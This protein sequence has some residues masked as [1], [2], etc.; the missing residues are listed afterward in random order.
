[1]SV[2]EHGAEACN[3]LLAVDVEMNTVD[4]Y[5]MSSW[6]RGYGDFE[7][8]PDSRT[9]RRAVA[10][11]HGAVPRGPRVGRRRAP[12]VASPRQILRRQ[13]D[14]LAERGLEAHGRDRARVHPLQDLLRGGGGARLPRPR[15][16]QP[17]QRRL[18]DPR[19][20]AGRAGD[21]PH[22]QRDGRRRPAR[23]GLQGRVQPRPARD[24]LRLRPALQTADEHAIYK[25]GAKEIAAQ[26][27]MAITFMAKFDEREGNSCHI[28]LSLRR[29]DGTPA[30]RRR[31]AGLRPLRRRPARLPARA[32]AVLRAQHQLLQALRRGL[33][34]PPPRSPGATT[35]APARCARSATGRARRIES[36]V[37]GR[38]RQPVPRARAR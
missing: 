30:V 21:P 18:L 11:G 22:P 13:L 1:M 26:E 5:E 4:G 10:R 37:P 38:R 7:M 34:S 28:H 35:T 6:E 19:H 14:R 33:A 9:L 17:V 20:R 24:Q 12:V 8:R 27:G 2:V 36:R 15:P 3:Y 23:R 32:D 29:E 31:P 16:G 25:N